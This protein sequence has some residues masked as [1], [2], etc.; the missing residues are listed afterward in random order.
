MSDIVGLSCNDTS[1]HHVAQNVN[2][3][4]LS[5]SHSAMYVPR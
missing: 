5:V 4:I 1:Q 2:I 3:G